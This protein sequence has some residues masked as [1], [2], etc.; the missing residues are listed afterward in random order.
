[1]IGEI[2]NTSDSNRRSGAERGE[3]RAVVDRKEELV[4]G[5]AVQHVV[6]EDR[7]LDAVRDNVVALVVQLLQHVVQPLPRRSGPL[8]EAYEGLRAV[9]KLLHLLG[10]APRGITMAVGGVVSHQRYSLD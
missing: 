10:A 3:R 1:M 4:R 6:Q 5:A 8:T 9:L 7:V 2:V